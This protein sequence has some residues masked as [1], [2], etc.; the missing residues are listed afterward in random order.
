MNEIQVRFP[1]V[2]FAARA[3]SEQCL[4]C[5]TQTSESSDLGIVCCPKGQFFR[6]LVWCILFP[7]QVEDPSDKRS[8]VTLVPFLWTR[9]NYSLVPEAE[10]WPLASRVHPKS[11]V[12]RLGWVNVLRLDRGG[13]WGGKSVPLR[14]Y[15][16]VARR[17]NCRK[18]VEGQ[19]K[20]FIA[21]LGAP[22]SLVNT[23]RMC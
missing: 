18:G 13:G 21:S 3:T 9:A 16:E 22:G 20:T 5:K 7:L 4:F 8:F 2:C 19:Y 1:F 17:Y 10:Q 14:P 6:L 12:G 23:A 15:V 11:V